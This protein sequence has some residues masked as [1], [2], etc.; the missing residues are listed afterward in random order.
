M[1]NLAFITAALTCV[2][3]LGANVQARDN[4]GFSLGYG[5]SDGFFGFSY[6]NN[7]WHRPGYGH[8]G[9]YPP[10]H[11]PDLYL[12]PKPYPVYGYPYPRPYPVYGYPAPCPPPVYVSPRPYPVPVYGYPAPCPVPV[13]GYP[14][15]LPVPVYGYP[16]PGC[17]PW[18]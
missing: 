13:Y 5:G 17:Y 16:R 18:R 14:V 9:I 1:K 7:N 3:W 10:P 2:L 8:G 12:Y 15:P 4:F 6:S 11:R